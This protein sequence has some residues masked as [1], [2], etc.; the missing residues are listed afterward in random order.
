MPKVV[1]NLFA[2]NKAF[3][4]VFCPVDKKINKK[5]KSQRK[6]LIGREGFFLNKQK[7]RKQKKSLIKIA[8]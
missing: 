2:L 1:L 4:Q 8:N 3:V 7:K 6:I 5:K